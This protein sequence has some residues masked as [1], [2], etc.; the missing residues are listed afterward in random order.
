[1]PTIEEVQIAAAAA[2]GL[3][4]WDLLQ[5]DRNGRTAKARIAAML[6][7]RRIPGGCSYPELGRAFGRDHTTVLVAVRRGVEL[8]RSDSWFAD[9][10]RHVERVVGLEPAKGAC[11]P[12]RSCGAACRGDQ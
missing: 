2:A 11:D 3:T 9:L 5:R 6:V 1:M 8:E 12:R 7:A 4:R 10:V